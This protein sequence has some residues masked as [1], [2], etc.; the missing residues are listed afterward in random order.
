[1]AILKLTKLSQGQKHDKVSICGVAKFLT[2]I[3]EKNSWPL[4]NKCMSLVWTTEG[5]YPT[6][7]TA[8]HS[9]YYFKS[10][11]FK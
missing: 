10:I 2:K 5:K 6:D 1:M 8:Y 11:L 4:A 9:R 3:A 7:N